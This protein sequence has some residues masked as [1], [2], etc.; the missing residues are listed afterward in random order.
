MRDVRNMMNDIQL[1]FETHEDLAVCMCEMAEE[2][3]TTI[4][5]VVFYEDAMSLLKSFGCINETKFSSMEIENPEWDGYVKEYYVCVDED[6][7]VSV[8]PAWRDKG[9]YN[10][11]CYVG[12]G[13][14]CV[15]L[16]HSN[17]NSKI[18]EV[19]KECDCVEFDIDADAECDGCCEECALSDDDDYDEDDE[20]DIDDF[21]E[22]FSQKMS[23]I[24]EATL[25]LY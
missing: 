22:E 1:S 16:V 10:E 15:V 18:L 4:Y 8:E 11:A 19:L 3:N 6:L 7:E 24:I 17:A 12:V 25:S 21:L 13:D 5:A 20:C 14:D 23:A 2:L 9:K